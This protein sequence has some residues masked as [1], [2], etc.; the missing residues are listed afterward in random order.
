M[1]QQRVKQWLRHTIWPH[2][3]MRQFPFLFQVRYNDMEKSPVVNQAMSILATAKRLYRAVNVYHVVE[4][5][6]GVDITTT[7]FSRW[8]RQHSVSPLLINAVNAGHF[9]AAV[10]CIEECME[11]VRFVVDY[12]ADSAFYKFFSLALRNPFAC[13][14]TCWTF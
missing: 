1:E 12:S 9:S 2:G 13:H 6:T 3:G 8:T 10:D 4:D 7:D 5:D 11:K 14:W